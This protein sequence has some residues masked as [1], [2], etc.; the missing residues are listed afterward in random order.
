[1][2]SANIGIN[3]FLSS[4]DRTIDNLDD[5]LLD[6]LKECG[7]IIVDESKKE[8][9]KHFKMRSGRALNSISILHVD[10]DSVEV[11][12]DGSTEYAEY[13]HNGSV[14]HSVEPVGKKALNWDGNKFSKGHVVSGIDGVPFMEIGIKN[15]ENKCVN[16]LD[17]KV[18]EAIKD[19]GI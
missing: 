9:L 17:K 15:S 8:F 16:L 13:L 7:E 19:A 1:M 18:N 11:G 6:G 12:L 14:T 3:D 4:L 5:Y 10:N 2:I